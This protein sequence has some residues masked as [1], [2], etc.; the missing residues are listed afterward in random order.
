MKEEEKKIK[1]RGTEVRRRK[2]RIISIRGGL[3]DYMDRSMYQFLNPCNPLI[4]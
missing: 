2:R 1:R 4:R 3:T